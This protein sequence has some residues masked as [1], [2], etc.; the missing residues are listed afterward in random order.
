MCTIAG[1]GER[2]LSADLIRNAA[3]AMTLGQGG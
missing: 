2:G 3:R 1:L